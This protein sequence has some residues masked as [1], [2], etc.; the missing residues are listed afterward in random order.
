[1]RQPPQPFNARQIRA[2]HPKTIGRSTINR[3]V[4]TTTVDTRF[5]AYPQPFNARPIRVRHPKTIGRSAMNRGFT[6]TTVDTRF[7]ADP[8]PFNARPIR[9]KSIWHPKGDWLIRDKSRS[10]GY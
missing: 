5:I 10:Y 4:T 7:I 3:G 2:L 6:G 9:D 1:M 8:Q